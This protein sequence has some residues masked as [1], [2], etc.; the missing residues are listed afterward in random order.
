MS[1]S[2]KLLAVAAVVAMTASVIFGSK[3][4][5]DDQEGFGEGFSWLGQKETIY[6]WYADENLSNYVNAAAVSFGEEKG[7]RVIPVLTSDNAYLEAINRSSMTAEEVPDVFIVGNDYLEKAYLAGLASRITDP[8]GICNEKHFPKAAMDAVTYR[9]RQVAYPLYYDTSVLAYNNT[10]LQEWVYQQTEKAINTPA[11]ENE[12]EILTEQEIP[13]DYQE[14]YDYYFSA[15]EKAS[16]PDT[17]DAILFIANSYDPPEGVEGVMAWDVSD[18]YYNYWLVGNYMAVGG[19]TGDDKSKVD[20][21]NDEVRKCLEKYKEMTQFFDISADTVSYETVVQDF[22]EGKMLF[23]IATTDIAARI[24]AAEQENTYGFDY[25]IVP[26]PDI[27]DKMQSRSLS[28]TGTAVVNGYS[29]HKELANEFASYL[30]GEFAGEIYARTGKTSA[31]LGTAKDP[32]L[33]VCMEEYAGSIPMPKMLE[34]A[35]FW[36]QAEILFYKIWNG[37]DIAALL[38]EL[39]TQ[40]FYQLQ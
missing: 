28:I 12:S 13:T 37:G 7:V 8:D 23:T 1:F 34:T 21:N 15:Y 24:R 9:G 14:R 36:M 39:D 27:D 19:D 6:C 33:Q 10:Y 31:N 30:A 38:Q 20:V 26:M 35:N 22:L 3:I 2:K 17:V 32:L 29:T 16:H 25:E 4:T 40:M 18:I 5:Q 11:E